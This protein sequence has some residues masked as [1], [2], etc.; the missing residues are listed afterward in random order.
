MEN[1]LRT[2]LLL[3]FWFAV[4]VPDLCFLTEHVLKMEGVWS[5]DFESIV[6]IN[7]LGIFIYICTVLDEIKSF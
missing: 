5:F 1:A 3:S 7:L 2:I 4:V 6:V